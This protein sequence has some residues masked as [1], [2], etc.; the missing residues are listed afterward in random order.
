MQTTKVFSDLLEAYVDPAVRVIGLKGST[1]SSKSWSTMQLLDWIGRKSRSPR[2]I[3]AVSETMPHLKRGVIR[4]FGNIL[5]KEGVYNNSAWHDT[6]K[7]YAY[8]NAVLEFFSADQAS[9]VHGPSRQVLYINEGINLGWETYRQ[10]A[11]RTTE[12]I[13]I[14]WN[15]AYE[16]WF[17]S[18]LI[19]RDDVRLIHSTYLDNDFLSAAQIAEIESNR[20]VDPEWWKVYGL[21]ET[22]SKAG[23]VMKKWDIVQAMPPRAEW[24]KAFIGVD[25]GWSNPTAVMLVVLAHGDLWFDELAYEKNLDNPEIAALIKAAGYKD[26]EVIADPAEPKSI[27]ELRTAGLNVAEKGIVKDIKLGLQ[28]M[29]RYKKHYTA[30]SLGSIDENRKY[31]Y[32][33]DAE[34]S[35]VED[36]PID[37]HNHAKDAERYVVLNRL[38]NISTGFDVTTSA[39][40]N[41]K[42][43]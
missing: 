18:K 28:V 42:N 27:K 26:L 5:K 39:R 22:G 41:R 40:K 23:L 43:S 20:E 37:K 10:L 24:K 2:L 21:G 7:T 13:I 35:Y 31:R 3:S 9:K 36:V 38:S 32:P 8:D 25:F 11:I 29:N 14:D 19:P 12:K 17:D 34:G 30:R 33:Q 16:F 4:D 15:P 1:R 6:N